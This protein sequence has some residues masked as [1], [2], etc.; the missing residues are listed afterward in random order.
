L[1]AATA[2]AAVAL[3]GLNLVSAMASTPGPAFID[4]VPVNTAEYGL[5]A[6]SL[7]FSLAALGVSAAIFM[8]WLFRSSKALDARGTFG[9]TWSSGWTLG[10]WF[11]PVANLFI[12]RLVVGEMEKIAH[13]PYAGEAVGIAWK[14]NRRLPI[15]DL[16]WLLWAGG[17]LVATFGEFGRLF[18]AEDDGRHTTLLAVTS[19]GYMMMAAGG[20]ALFVLIRSLTKA[21]NG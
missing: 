16:W 7:F 5:W 18:G 14:Q 12:P 15:G 10:A 21:A 1:V 13:V 8:V 3:A 2:Q 6:L 11:I 9:R 17:N 19:L 20:V 4:D